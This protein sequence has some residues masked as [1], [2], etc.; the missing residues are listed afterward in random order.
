MNKNLLDAY[1]KLVP[2]DQAVI[3][4]MII[5]LATKDKEISNLCTYIKENLK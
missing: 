5:A 3:D 4:A 1:K 2:A